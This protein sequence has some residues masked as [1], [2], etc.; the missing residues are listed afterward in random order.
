MY[1]SEKINCEGVKQCFQSPMQY[2][3]RISIYGPYQVYEN[4]TILITEKNDLKPQD[5]YTGDRM[6][7]HK[8][9]I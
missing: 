3:L 4:Q 2:F 9:L 5:C 8:I 1:C 7:K 6:A